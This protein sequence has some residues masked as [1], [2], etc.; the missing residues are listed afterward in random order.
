MFVETIILGAF[1]GYMRK[2]SFDNLQFVNIRGMFLIILAGLFQAAPLLLFRFSIFADKLKWFTPISLIILLICL[3]INIDQP[4]MRIIVIGVGMNLLVLLMNGLSM[5]IMFKA[6][7]IAGMSDMSMPIAMG[8]VINYIPFSEAWG[9]S[10]YLGKIIPIP[11]FYPF[12]K[13]LS[14]GDVIIMIGII[15]FIAKSMRK[16]RFRRM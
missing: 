15:M 6:L 16:Y 2:G 11:K 12:A 4:G 14:I 8:E 9:I 5:P 3:F 1:I 13:V 7:T 10:G